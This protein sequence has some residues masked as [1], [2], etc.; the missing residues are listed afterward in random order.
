MSKFI[1]KALSKSA[2][3]IKARFMYR[4]SKIM[5][6]NLKDTKLNESN[7][8]I[9]R[10]T[11]E[12]QNRQNCLNRQNRQNRREETSLNLKNHSS[13]REATRKIR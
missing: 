5:S 1:I 12:N 11:N 2:I 8:E 3:N 4:H 6:R 13:Y 10:L 7:N 9:I